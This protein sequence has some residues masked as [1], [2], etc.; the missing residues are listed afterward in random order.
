MAEYEDLSIYSDGYSPFEIL[1][2]GWLGTSQGVTVDGT[3]MPGRLFD[4]LAE[5]SKAGVSVQLS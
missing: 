2:I 1:N 5:E 3:P 4:G